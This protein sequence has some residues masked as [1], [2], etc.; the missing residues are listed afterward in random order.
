MTSHPPSL[1]DYVRLFE[2]YGDDISSIYLKPNDTRYE[3]L[4][5]QA[6]RLLAQPSEFNT[7]L[8]KPFRV[9]AQKYLAGDEKTQ[10]HM[11]YPENRH[12]MGMK[13]FL[14]HPEK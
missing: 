8:P 12:F 9:T 6:A 1:E 13:L 10:R 14:S 7:T 5:E 4:F 11:S 2:S 3:L